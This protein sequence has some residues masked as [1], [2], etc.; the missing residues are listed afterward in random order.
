MI[1]L[2]S[3]AQCMTAYPLFLKMVY[4]MKQLYKLTRCV[5][6]FLLFN[7]NVTGFQ[8]ASL[9]QTWRLIHTRVGMLCLATWMCCNR[10]FLAFLFHFI[11][12][13]SPAFYSTEV[14][15]FAV[16]WHLLELESMCSV[17]CDCIF[18]LFFSFLQSRESEL[19]LSCHCCVRCFFLLRAR[20]EKALLSELP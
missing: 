18:F 17:P 14:D 5:P 3:L 6:F 15:A 19:P 11:A 20:L 4:G 13:C 8:Q 1:H 10:H 16:C 2:E 9:L 12:H 7:Q